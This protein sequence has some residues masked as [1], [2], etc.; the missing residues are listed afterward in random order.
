[1]PILP[2]VVGHTV[3]PTCCNESL[4]RITGHINE[5]MV[6]LTVDAP[7]LKSKNQ[8]VAIMLIIVFVL[9]VVVNA[10]VVIVFIIVIACCMEVVVEG[11]R[12]MGKDGWVAGEGR[13]PMMGWSCRCGGGEDETGKGRLGQC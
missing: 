2:S 9:V 10:L 5:C 3:D 4:P 1:M 13:G 8:Q 12:V 11:E 7:L 6:N